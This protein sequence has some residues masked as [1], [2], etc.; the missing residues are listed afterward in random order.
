MYNQNFNIM[1]KIELDSAEIDR[2][3]SVAVNFLNDP[4]KVDVIV[5]KALALTKMPRLRASCNARTLLRA[6]EEFFASEPRSDKERAVIV[7]C[8]D[9]AKSEDELIG[10]YEYS[11]CKR[12][13]DESMVI[14]LL[15]R[16]MAQILFSC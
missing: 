14:K 11:L 6:Q 4:Y 12:A 1:K 10:I 7:R 15:I 13:K 2:L 9:L 3:A 16:K 8:I 5:A